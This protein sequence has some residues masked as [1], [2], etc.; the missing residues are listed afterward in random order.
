[1]IINL[2]NTKFQRVGHISCQSGKWLNRAIGTS[3][4]DGHCVFRASLRLPKFPS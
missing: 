2:S 1:M 3:S 4:S